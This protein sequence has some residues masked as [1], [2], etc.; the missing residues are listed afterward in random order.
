MIQEIIVQI[1][2]YIAACDDMGINALGKIFAQDREKISKAYVNVT[3]TCY[4]G[5]SKK[6]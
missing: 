1:V 5:G 4:A 3:A 2:L 6:Q